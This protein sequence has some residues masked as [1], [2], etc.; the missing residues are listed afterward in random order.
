MCDRHKQE[1]LEAQLVAMLRMRGQLPRQAEKMYLDQFA[2]AALPEGS[3]AEI[4]HL[5]ASASSYDFSWHW[6]DSLVAGADGRLGSLVRRKTN[7]PP[8]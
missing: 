1:L 5:K 7:S 3:P 4:D 8:S 6:A 2:K